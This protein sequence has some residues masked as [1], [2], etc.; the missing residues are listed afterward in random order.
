M[1][2]IQSCF[3]GRCKDSTTHSYYH[4][5]KRCTSCNLET[6]ADTTVEALERHLRQQQDERY[7]KNLTPRGQTKLKIGRFE[8]WRWYFKNGKPARNPMP[9]IIRI[10]FF[11]WQIEILWD[12][13]KQTS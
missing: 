10:P 7:E 4:G 8:I 3:C 13:R 5:R 9:F 2:Y 11:S 1:E 12:R 6:V